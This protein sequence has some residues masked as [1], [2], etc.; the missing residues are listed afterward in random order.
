M[1]QFSNKFSWQEK[2][3]IHT[4][5]SF[6]QHLKGKKLKLFTFG[7]MILVWKKGYYS[8]IRNALHW[9]VKEY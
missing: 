3:I 4:R 6:Y 7:R 5:A 8:R 2:I 1:E 9:T